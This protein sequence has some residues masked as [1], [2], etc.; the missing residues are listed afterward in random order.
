MGSL[1]GRVKV[2]HVCDA[3]FA[4]MLTFSDL[5]LPPCVSSQGSGVEEPRATHIPNRQVP[6]A[7]RPSF[8]GLNLLTFAPPLHLLR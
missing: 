3:L 5:T 4:F 7:S 6:R 2:S 8:A 1:R